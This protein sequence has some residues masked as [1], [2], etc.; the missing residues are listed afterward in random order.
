ME[1]SELGYKAKFAD[2]L[3]W[4]K[5]ILT[6]V[7]RWWRNYRTRKAL[8]HLSDHLMEDIGLTPAQAR[9]ESVRH[10]WDD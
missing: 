2:T 5:K 4:D 3:G 10:F 1:T 6:K 7:S 8:S 9:Q